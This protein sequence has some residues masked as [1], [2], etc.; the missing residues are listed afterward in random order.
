MQKK[1]KKDWFI[2][3]HESYLRTESKSSDG[4]DLNPSSLFCPLILSFLI[5]VSWS[6]HFPPQTG[7]FSVAREESPPCSSTPLRKEPLSAIPPSVLTS[8]SHGPTGSHALSLALLPEWRGIFH[9]R[10]GPV[11]PPSTSSEGADHHDWGAHSA[12]GEREAGSPRQACGQT[13]HPKSLPMALW[14]RRQAETSTLYEPITLSAR[15]LA[16]QTGETQGRRVNTLLMKA[17][18]SE[19]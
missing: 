7:L 6:H 14:W 8:T 16:F 3:K 1:K 13:E 19:L 12:T 4:A 9:S 15:P 17:N 5:Y 10:L 11:T 2:S 18:E